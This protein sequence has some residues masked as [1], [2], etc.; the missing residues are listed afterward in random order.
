MEERRFT[1]LVEADEGKTRFFNSELFIIKDVS[2]IRFWEDT[3]LGNSPLRDQYPQLYNI[4]RKKQDTVADELSTHILNL[5][6][7]RDLIGIKLV[8]WNNLV[9]RLSTIDLTQKRDGF[10][11]NLDQ[12]SV[13]LVKSHYLGLINQNTPNLN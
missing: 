2:Q 11:W 5:S 1:F 10:K 12:T 7:R 9:S 8:I 6:W 13:F 3:W 4:V